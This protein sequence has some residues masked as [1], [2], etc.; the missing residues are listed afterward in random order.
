MIIDR[1]EN[2]KLYKGLHP[3]VDQALDYI[4]T[5]PRAELDQLKPG[6]YTLSPQLDAIIDEYETQSSE[7]KDY[8]A[9]KTFIDV[10]FILAGEEY[11]GVAPLV[12]QTP[13]HAYNPDKDFALYQV[14]GQMFKVKAGM[15]VIFFPTDLHLP[16][17][18]MPAKHVRKLVMKARIQG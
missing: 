16:S 13:V 2:A 7:G 14:S 5:T 6:R 8:E 17:I 11:M 12:N 10:Q 15:F 3:S 1:I 4:A 9:H 18:G